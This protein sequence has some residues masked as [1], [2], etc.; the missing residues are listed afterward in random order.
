MH[1]ALSEQIFKTKFAQ[2][3]ISFNLIL[4]E[5][6]LFGF[7]QSMNYVKSMNLCCYPFTSTFLDFYI[8]IDLYKFFF[9]IFEKAINNI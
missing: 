1:G 5:R 3:F 6:G 8:C 2:E 4:T 7:I 9:C